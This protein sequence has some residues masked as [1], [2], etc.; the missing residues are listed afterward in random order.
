MQQN[1]DLDTNDIQLNANNNL[2]IEKKIWNKYELDIL[3]IVPTIYAL[4]GNNHIN[5]YDSDSICNPYVGRC[6]NAKCK[7]IIILELKLYQIRFPE[8]KYLQYYIFLNCQYSKKKNTNDICKK[9]KQEDEN[10]TL[11][12]EKMQQIL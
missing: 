6:T 12:K 8:Q 1:S 4:C 7:E 10:I 9:I 2:Q 5:I 3:V 11:S